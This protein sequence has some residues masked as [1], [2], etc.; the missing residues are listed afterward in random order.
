MPATITW[1]VNPNDILTTTKDG[2]DDFVVRVGYII[3]GTDGVNTI[4]IPYTASFDVPGQAFTPYASL[5]EAQMI[6]WAQ[7]AMG[8]SQLANLQVAMDKRLEMQANPPPPVVQ[9]PAPWSA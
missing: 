3:T 8:Q 2:K 9:K 5:T 6:A 1:A 4:Q 7:D